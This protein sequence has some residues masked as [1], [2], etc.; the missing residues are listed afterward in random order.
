MVWH[1]IYRFC[2]VQGPRAAPILSLEELMPKASYLLPAP[3]E[4]SL[5]Y[6]KLTSHTVVLATNKLREHSSMMMIM[7]MIMREDEFITTLTN[8]DDKYSPCLGPHF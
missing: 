8:R 3:R 2:A 7:M 1:Y 6:S 5:L 4:D